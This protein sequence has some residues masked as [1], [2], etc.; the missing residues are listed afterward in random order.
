MTIG[1]KYQ[2]KADSNPAP[3]QY[4]PD[5][6]LIKSKSKAAIIVKESG[7]K[8]PKESNPSPGEYDGHIT[9]FGSDSKGMT[10]QGKY[11]WK[12]D[13]NPAPG[14]YEPFDPSKPRSI[15]AKVSVP[16]SP[17]KTPE[18]TPGPGETSFMTAFGNDSRGVYIGEKWKTKIEQTPG[19][20]YYDNINSTNFTKSRATGG[21]INAE[22][23]VYVDANSLAGPSRT[24][25]QSRGEPRTM[26]MSKSVVFT[27]SSTK[28]AKVRPQTAVK[29]STSNLM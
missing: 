23:M 6:S 8:V 13:S 14:Q 22:Q 3:G 29:K 15:S 16:M 10:I 20:G 26:A 28:K 21:K 11:Q 5:Q 18:Y 4:E 25:Y 27:S 19:P 12:P 9:A 7:Y 17:T 2:W 24:I 1:K